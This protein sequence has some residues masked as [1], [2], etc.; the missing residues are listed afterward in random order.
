MWTSCLWS[1]CAMSKSRHVGWARRRLWRCTSTRALIR[2]FSH[3]N[4]VYEKIPQFAS[5]VIIIRNIF[6][7]L[8]EY[9]HWSHL[10]GFSFVLSW[11]SRCLTAALSRWEQP[12]DSTKLLISAFHGPLAEKPYLFVRRLFVR[13]AMVT[14]EQIS[15]LLALDPQTHTFSESLW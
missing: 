10:K 5:H 6:F 7:W 14:P 3:N 11:A 13:P 15:L 1:S 9:L 4:P 12:S 8:L 2:L